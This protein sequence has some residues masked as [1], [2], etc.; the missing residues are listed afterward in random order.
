MIR[1]GTGKCCI[2][3]QTPVRMAGYATRNAPFDGVIQD[4][5]TRVYVL[6]QNGTQIVLVYG[7]LLWWNSAFVS[8]ARPRLAEVLCIPEEQILFVAS[9]NHSGPGTGD[10]FTPLLETVEEAYTQYLYH[11]VEETVLQ[12]RQNLEK[13][14]AVSYEG[15]CSLNVYRR[16]T[17]E[18]GVVMAPNYAV[19]ADNHLTLVRFVRMDGR[20]KGLLIHYPCHANLSD[21]NQIHPDYPGVA[22][23]LLE[24]EYPDCIP[25]F[26]QGCTGDL[27]PNSVLG[28]RFVPQ[29][30]V[31]VQN[32]AR[33]FADHCI[34]VLAK[35]GK[36]LGD[37]VRIHR[38]TEKLP[39]DQGCI[40]N[41]EKSADAGDLSCQQWLAACEKKHFRNYELLELSRLEI[42]CL[43]LFFFNSE[44]SQYYAAFAKTL[45]EDALTS[46]YTNGMIGY[47]PDRL[48]IQEG[49]YEPEGSAVYFAVAGTYPPDIQKVIENALAI[50]SKEQ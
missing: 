9:H 30:F 1:L 10:N 13:V 26:L 19:P 8:W 42:G 35:P 12:A 6:E 4:I 27:R 17:T 5:F 23:E 14:S 38:L 20:T 21:G 29:N 7:D 48:Q 49:G 22:M 47:L 2:T 11:R 43:N 24:Q 16:V 46:G 31:G 45:K 44:V 15:S 28:G 41:R 3:P 50:L 32:F 18:Q 39:V 25:V 33:Q 34:R 37:G 40:L 36:P